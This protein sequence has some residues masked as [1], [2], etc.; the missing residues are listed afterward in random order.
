MIFDAKQSAIAA[1]MKSRGFEYLPEPYRA[2]DGEKN[3]W[4]DVAYARERGYGLNYSGEP[5]QGASTT[6]EDPPRNDISRL[7]PATRTAWQ[8]ALNGA[9]V[10]DPNAIGKDPDLVEIKTAD[11]A[12]YFSRSA[13]RTY[14]DEQVQGDETQWMTAEKRVEDLANEVVSAVDADPRIAAKKRDWAECMAA[15]GY[16]VTEPETAPEVIMDKVH[17][18]QI[19]QPEARKQEIAMATADAECVNSVGALE[20]RR[21]VTAEQAKAVTEAH[22]NDIMAFVELRKKAVDR[23][24]ALARQ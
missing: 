13:C 19:A 17:S 4:G 22:E 6:T 2:P 12:S 11:G 23:A 9:S 5:D 8:A 1:C 20:V 3:P 21:Q 15:R 16:Q 24:T 18:G 14:G 10:A 7:P